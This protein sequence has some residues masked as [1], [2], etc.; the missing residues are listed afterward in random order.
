MAGDHGTGQSWL[1]YRNCQLQQ[2]SMEMETE[3]AAEK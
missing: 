2:Q 1:E 3:A